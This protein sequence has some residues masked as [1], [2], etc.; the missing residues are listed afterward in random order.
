MI[1][2]ILFGFGLLIIAPCLFALQTIHVTDNVNSQFSI[3]ANDYSRIFVDGDRI[4]SFTST[5]GLYDIRQDAINGEIFI[6]PASNVKQITGL[7][8]TENN[9]IYPVK[10]HVRMGGSQAVMLLSPDAYKQKARV[11]ESDS[12]YQ[13]LI[14]KL[15]QAMAGGEFPEG[16]QVKKV[17]R[18]SDYLGSVAKINLIKIYSGAKVSGWV[19][20]LNNISH[21]TLHIKPYQL[22]RKNARA[23]AL[24]SQTIAPQH[25]TL[26]YMVVSND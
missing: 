12:T 14:I 26:V 25:S 5:K 23:I 21:Q 1:K 9:H 18:K 15:M 24:L 7:I 13:D 3:A 16:Y 17:Q 22:Y 8:T 4:I 10:M 20:V 6:K 11:W 19:L 2:K